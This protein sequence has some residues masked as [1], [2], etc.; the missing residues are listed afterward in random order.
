MTIRVYVQ[1]EYLSDVKLVEVD[2]NATLHDLKRAAQELLPAGT[3]VS[4]LS[5]SVEDDQ[6][7]DEEA[8]RPEV[9]HVRDL[10]K[11]HGI[12]VHLHHCK[13]VEVCVRFANETVHRKFRPATTVGR[14]RNWAGGKL[15]MDPG[16][17]AEHVLQVSGTTEQPDVDVHIG[18]LARC[19]QCSVTFDLV[20][21]H[22]IN[23]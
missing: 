6:E 4:E 9:I 19:P 12:R 22:R 3:D 5:L 17:I 14:V 23:G 10:K 11:G 20:P 18:A 13:H 8:D 1:S 21:A 15:G 7:V 16:D 2:D